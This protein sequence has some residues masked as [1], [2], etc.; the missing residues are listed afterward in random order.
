MA[1]E[2]TSTAHVP[3]AMIGAPKM[4]ERS[5]WSCLTAFEGAAAATARWGAASVAGGVCAAHAPAAAIAVT[6]AA[7]LTSGKAAI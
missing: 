5:D 2:R 6:A 7:R 3:R 1:S 4:A